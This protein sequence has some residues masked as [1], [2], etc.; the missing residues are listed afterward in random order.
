MKIEI[1][2]MINS[3]AHF[4][5]LVLAVNSKVGKTTTTT[6]KLSSVEQGVPHGSLCGPLFS[7]S[8]RVH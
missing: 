5:R 4:R 1:I 6:T 2:M 8:A 3:L 7:L